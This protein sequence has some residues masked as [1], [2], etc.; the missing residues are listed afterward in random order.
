MPAPPPDRA[1]DHLS[2]PEP[3]PDVVRVTLHSQYPGFSEHACG[4]SDAGET[5]SC[6]EAAGVGGTGVGCVVA[7]VGMALG[8]TTA[9]LVLEASCVPLVMAEEEGVVGV[10]VGIGCT[11]GDD[12][13]EIGA[14]A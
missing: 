8:T 9:R 4:A 3:E 1:I 14:D 5:W 13:G 7:G 10:T 6:R 2:L 11:V 12:V